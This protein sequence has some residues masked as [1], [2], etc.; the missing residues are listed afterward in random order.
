MTTIHTPEPYVYHMA[1]S[2]GDSPWR[3]HGPAHTPIAGVQT[4][5]TPQTPSPGDSPT[6]TPQPHC[7][8]L[9][10]CPIAG[11]QLSIYPIAGDEPHVHP[12]APL[13]GDSPTDTPQPAE[14]GTTLLTY[15]GWGSSS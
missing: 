4:T 1:P 14:K 15:P 8:G 10:P 6:N 7:E 9:A 13:L 2:L 11:D 3:T 5:H 12:M